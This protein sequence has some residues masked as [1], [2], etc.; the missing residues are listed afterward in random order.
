MDHFGV[1]SCIPYSFLSRYVLLIMELRKL[2]KDLEFKSLDG[3]SSLLDF[4]FTAQAL[5]RLLSSFPSQLILLLIV[6][7][8]EYM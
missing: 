8:K 2:S 6:R 1:E 3:I 4:E 5:L 7:E